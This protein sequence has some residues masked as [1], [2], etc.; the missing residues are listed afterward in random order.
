MTLSLLLGMVIGAAMGLTGAGG[1]ILAVPAL[2]AGMGWTMQQA[3]PAALIA[4]A[5]GSALGV[6]EAWAQGLVRYRAAVLIAVIGLPFASLGIRVAQILPQS[7]LMFLFGCVMLI[8]AVRVLRTTRADR[9]PEHADARNCVGCID[10]DTGRFDWNRQTVLLFAAIGTTAGFMSGLLGVGGGFIIVPLLRR[11]TNVTM[12][13][14][15]ATSLLVITLT[16]AGGVASAAMHGVTLPW[17]ETAWFAAATAIGMLAGRGLAR[18]L[19]AA[20][21]Q[22]GFAMVLI[23]VALGL[24]GNTLTAI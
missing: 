13:G 16:S 19:P 12:H 6:V 15:V 20:Y 3:V 7:S 21:L 22:R 4:V 17:P 18:R 11:F 14:V 9:M 8:V 23:A 1:G 24:V 10:P 5:C 2:V